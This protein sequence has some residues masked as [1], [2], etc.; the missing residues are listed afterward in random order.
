MMD[1]RRLRFA[2]PFFIAMTRAVLRLRVQALILNE[3]SQ[4][5]QANW[6]A[7][8]PPSGY[9]LNLVNIRRS[10]YENTLFFEIPV[11]VRGR[12]GASL[13]R[14][15]RPWQLASDSRDSFRCEPNRSIQRTTWR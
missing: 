11:R 2:D 3:P 4:A 13:R 5:Q 7:S 8:F 6:T 14:L 15:S 1:F 9:G 12:D 10:S